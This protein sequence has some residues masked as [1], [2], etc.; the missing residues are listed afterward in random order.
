M[1]SFNLTPKELKILTIIIKLLQCRVWGT[2]E[3]CRVMLHR[4]H[5]R[6][7][8][9]SLSFSEQRLVIEP[10]CFTR[11]FTRKKVE[12]MFLCKKDPER[13]NE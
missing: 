12:S 4:L 8:E 1:I 10:G 6:M 13:V 7:E 3:I 9:R 11:F 5:L 2:S